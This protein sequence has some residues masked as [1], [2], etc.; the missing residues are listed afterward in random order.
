VKEG[1]GAPIADEDNAYII[2]QVAFTLTKDSV[3]EVGKKLLLSNSEDLWAIR[4]LFSELVPTPGIPIRTR[5][6]ISCNPHHLVAYKKAI[7]RLEESLIK[8]LFNWWENEL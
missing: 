1:I 3:Q 8:R 4:A 6:S 5:T 2:V 7:E